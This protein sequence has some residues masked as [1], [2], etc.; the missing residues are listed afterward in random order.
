MIRF[1]SLTC[2]L[3]AYEHIVPKNQ[4]KSSSSHVS[5]TA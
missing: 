5:A 4:L 2:T 1:L 3:Q